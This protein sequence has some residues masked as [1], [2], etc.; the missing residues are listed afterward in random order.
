MDPEGYREVCIGRHARGPDHVEE[1]AVLRESIANVIGAITDTGR[2]IS[3]CGLGAIED[4]IQGL[5]KLESLC[6]LYKMRMC[7]RASGA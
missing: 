1:E 3:L 4:C 5:C 2:W 7:K 6:R